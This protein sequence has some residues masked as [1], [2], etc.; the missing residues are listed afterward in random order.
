MTHVYTCKH[1]FVT[2]VYDLLTFA[3]VL[4]SLD[5][6]QLQSRNQE[7]QGVKVTYISNELNG[8]ATNME[9]QQTRP[10]TPTTPP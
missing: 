7:D 5:V 4:L 8:D 1:F 9:T 3:S 6:P 2:K 10:Q